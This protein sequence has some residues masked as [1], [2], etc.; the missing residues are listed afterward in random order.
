M[1]PELAENKVFSLPLRRVSLRSLAKA[2]QQR[3]LLRRRELELQVPP[4]GL[5]ILEV[6]SFAPAVLLRLHRNKILSGLRFQ[7]GHLTASTQHIMQSTVI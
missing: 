4:Q 7:G 6:P 5:R 2:Q 3:E 1:I